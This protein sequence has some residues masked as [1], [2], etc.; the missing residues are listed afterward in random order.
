MSG[1]LLQTLLLEDSGKKTF[2]HCLSF[3]TEYSHMWFISCSTNK[4]L[5]INTSD[6]LFFFLSHFFHSEAPG[7]GVGICLAHDTAYFISWA[8]DGGTWNFRESLNC[9]AADSLPF[10]GHRLKE[11]VHSK[12]KVEVTQL[13]LTLRSH[14][15][16]SPWNSPG[17]NTGMGSLSLLQEISPTQGLNPGLP[18]CRRTLYQ[19]SHN[20]SLVCISST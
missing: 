6:H 11:I 19:L 16:Y 5:M 4:I 17:Q 2:T 12:V 1:V 15:L 20:A 13:C 10:F 14:G 18:H 3:I 9:N 7:V 8:E